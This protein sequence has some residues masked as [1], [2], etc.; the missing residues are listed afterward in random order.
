VRTRRVGVDYDMWYGAVNSDIS[1]PQVGH[2]V[3]PHDTAQ[4]KRDSFNPVVSVGPP[5]TWDDQRVNV[6][7]VVPVTLDDGVRYLMFYR[8]GRSPGTDRVGLA[9]SSTLEGPWTKWV[10]NPILTPSPGQW[11]GTVTTAGS[12][13]IEVTPSDTVFHMW[14][15]GAM[16]PTST[17]PFKIGHAT[18]S[19]NSTLLKSLCPADPATGADDKEQLPSMYALSQ[20]YPN[21]FNPSTTIRYGLPVRS[22][23]TLAVF[24]T[25]GQQVGTL[26]HGEQEAGYHEAVF[27]ATGVASGVYLYRLQAGSF[28]QTKRMLILK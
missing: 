19:L 5:G 18:S 1:M 14:Y 17:Y 24:N 12:V 8:G 26:V 6:P 15:S 28:V 2:A 21:P 3:F 7:I 4:W 27:D 13:L 22:H 23:V 11:D 20:N 10:G 9:Y 25:L 16:T